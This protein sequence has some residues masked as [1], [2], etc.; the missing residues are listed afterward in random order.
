MTYIELV[1]GVLRRL[2]ENEVGVLASDEYATMIGDFVNDAKTFI[3]NSWNWS[4]LRKE[5]TL[6]TVTGQTLYPLTTAASY[7]II[8]NIFSPELQGNMEEITTTNMQYKQRG[9]SVPNG[10]PNEWSWYGVSGGQKQI[11]LYNAPAT[12]TTL[13]V[14]W[15]QRSP[16][17]TLEADVL[18][19]PSGEV[20]G[21]PSA[22]IFLLA[23][24]YLSDAIAID[25]NSS[26][27]YTN[28]YTV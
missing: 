25:A 21:Q 7:D 16:D 8:T 28:F 3:E 22:E 20:Q 5:T 13:T 24:R 12:P 10:V 23:D 19:I 6:T 15:I 11:A 1:N 26:E 18:L 17:F 9:V 14:D 27:E 4:G 2:R